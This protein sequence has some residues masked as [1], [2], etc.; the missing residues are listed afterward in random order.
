MNK[1]M[2]HKPIIKNEE[3]NLINFFKYLFHINN[4]IIRLC[5]FLLLLY[6]IYFFVKTPKYSSSVS[7]Y[8][9]Y[10]AES[11]PTQNFLSSLG[12]DF[13]KETELQFSVQNYIQSDKFLNEIVETIFIVN[14]NKI[15][16]IDLWGVNYNKY[17][18][19][20]PL[21]TLK[22]LNRNIS[23]GKN[24][25]L[26]EKKRFHAKNL[27]QENMTLTEDSESSLSILSIIVKNHPDLSKQIIESAYKSIINFSYQITK[28][29]SEE[30]ISFIKTQLKDVEKSL[31]K[32]EDDMIEFLESNNSIKS[33]ALLVKK[34]RLETEISLFSQLYISLNDQ[35]ELAK[36]E[37][38]DITSSIYLLDSPKIS[39]LKSGITLLKGYIILGIITYIFSILFFIYKDRKEI[40]SID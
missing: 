38:Q 8:T 2:Q 29:K 13:F 24:I 7:F 20:N 35:L 22:L 14:E 1:K 36:I 6:T 11:S 33:P 26:D 27:L 9:N 16:L 28:I 40:I 31:N 25:G 18:S 4:K 39:P 3:I 34:N 23:F 17:L 10:N 5:I 21:A 32:A 37:Q 30:K 15:T 12:N 19:L